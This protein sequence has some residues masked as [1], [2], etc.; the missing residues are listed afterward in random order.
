MSRQ[1]SHA[2]I[3]LLRNLMPI[4]NL[5]I[6]GE[7]PVG[8]HIATV[9]EVEDRFGKSNDRRKLLMNGLKNALQQF[10][11]VEVKKVFVDGSFTTD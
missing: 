7:L 2:I 5:E 6:N 10:A 8:M 9:E 11:K 4:P 3:V 1:I